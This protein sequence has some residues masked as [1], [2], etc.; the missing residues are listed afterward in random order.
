M[1]QQQPFFYFCAL[2]PFNWLPFLDYVGVKV[3]GPCVS[4]NFL[5]IAMKMSFTFSPYLAEHYIYVRFFSL[6]N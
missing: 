6:Q 4:D 5:A 2:F 3:L 1:S